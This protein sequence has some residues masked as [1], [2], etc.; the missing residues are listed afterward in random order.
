M[1]C[2]NSSNKELVGWSVTHTHHP[3]LEERIK[4][5]AYTCTN[6]CDTM[7][8]FEERPFDIFSS[9]SLKHPFENKNFFS[10]LLCSKHSWPSCISGGMCPE[11]WP[12]LKL[13]RYYM[14]LKSLCE[15][16]DLSLSGKLLLLQ[17]ESMSMCADQKR[18]IQRR[19]PLWKLCVISRVERMSFPKW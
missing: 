16:A 8:A 19:A 18:S 6:K 15:V 13:K 17:Q 11:A 2:T 9:F 12:L 3:N 10:E 4:S 1:T 7:N 14:R 5:T